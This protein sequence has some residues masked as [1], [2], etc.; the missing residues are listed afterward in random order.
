MVSLS[1][2]RF[3]VFWGPIGGGVVPFALS[4]SDD[5]SVYND[6]GPPPYLGGEGDLLFKEAALQVIEFS[7]CL[8]PTDGVVIDVSPRARHN[9]SLGTNDGTGY[10][11]N[12]YTGNP[13]E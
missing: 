13:Y 8:D 5:I 7:S 12:P 3:K 1:G 2:G 6:P 9:N 4:R 11:V 10:P